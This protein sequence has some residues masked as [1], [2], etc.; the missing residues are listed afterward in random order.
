MP[1]HLEVPHFGDVL[2]DEDPSQEMEDNMKEIY[3]EREEVRKI[4]DRGRE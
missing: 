4:E 1:E 3:L 2:T